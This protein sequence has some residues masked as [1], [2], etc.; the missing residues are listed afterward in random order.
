M[1]SAKGYSYAVQTTM[2]HVQEWRVL[3]LLVHSLL[4]HIDMWHENQA[5]HSSCIQTRP[6]LPHSYHCKDECSRCALRCCWSHLMSLCKH[7]LSCSLC[8]HATARLLREDAL[9]AVCVWVCGC[10]YS[11]ATVY[12]AF[13][14]VPNSC[15]RVRLIF[16]G[17]PHSW[18]A[19]CCSESNI[20]VK[21]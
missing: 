18:N 12:M 11:K 8:V 16:P 3:H 14:H 1:F 19:T 6:G 20:G 21:S 4:K 10:V 17:F 2:L 13:Q 7:F 9:R 15:L 5:H